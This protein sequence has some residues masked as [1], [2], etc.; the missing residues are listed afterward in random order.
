MDGGLEMIRIPESWLKGNRPDF[1]LLTEADLYQDDLRY[2][3]FGEE[4]NNEIL[5]SVQ[6]SIGQYEDEHGMPHARA[7]I[8]VQL[9]IQGHSCQFREEGRLTEPCDACARE[10]FESERAR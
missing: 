1:P 2:F 7:G 6:D 8:P 10:K 3:Y 5:K 4:A 9:Q